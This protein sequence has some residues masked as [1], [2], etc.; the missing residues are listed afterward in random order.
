MKSKPV[1]AALLLGFAPVLQAAEFRAV[2]GHWRYDLTGQVTDRG[3][4]YDFERDLGLRPSGR[5]SLLLDYDT[6]AGW[7]DFAVS[8]SQFG[9]QG[10]RSE[11]GTV[12]IGPIPIGS[13]TRRLAADADFDDFDL[14]ARLPLRLGSA[15]LSLGLTV[16]RLR[17]ELVIDDSEEPA[18][19]RQNYD[20]IFPELHAQLR[21]PWSR[22]LTLAAT[23]QGIEYRGSAASEYR[24]A[25][26]LRLGR[27][28]LEG[29]WQ[30]KRY[31]ITLDNYRLD[32]RLN[33]AL[34]RAGFILR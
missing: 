2:A 30:E 10:E 33:G 26:E 25:L 20:E 6:K 27:L 15:S 8:Y 21:W 12:G 17:G 18:P 7:P 29:G 24:A 11:T 32:S 34:L 9:A 14:T 13:E 31:E 28:L 22:F 5:R 3:Q 23:L 16:K 1:I 19:R 4:T